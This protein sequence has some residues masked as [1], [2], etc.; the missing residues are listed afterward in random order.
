[1]ARMSAPQPFGYLWTTFGQLLGNFRMSPE[2]SA[3]AFRGAW[4]ATRRQLVVAVVFMPQSASPRPPSNPNSNEGGR[5]PRWPDST[6]PTSKLSKTTIAGPARDHIFWVCRIEA[7][8]LHR[9]SSK[10]ALGGQRSG[11]FCPPP[12]APPDCGQF[13]RPLP[14]PAPGAAPD[15]RRLE[16]RWDGGHS[17][18]LLFVR[19]AFIAPVLW[20]G[21]PV[22]TSIH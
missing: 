2:A 16:G 7:R 3:V 10:S 12:G 6:S 15:P 5:P 11:H 14:R 18:L 9:C 17:A 13:C 1:M 20:G 22:D 21:P 19:S 8:Q 4:Q